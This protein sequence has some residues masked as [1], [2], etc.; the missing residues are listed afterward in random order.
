MFEFISVVI[1][2]LCLGSVAYCYLTARS[3]QQQKMK[4]YQNEAAAHRILM[5]LANALRMPDE[6]NGLQKAIR[7]RNLN[8]EIISYAQSVES[9]KETDTAND[10]TVVNFWP[11]KE[12][13]V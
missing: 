9:S 11:R 3:M 5:N 2:F 7:V 8:K 4:T 10:E 12:G 6:Q 13:R 1:V